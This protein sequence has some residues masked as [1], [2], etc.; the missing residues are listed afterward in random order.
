MGKCKYCFCLLN[1]YSRTML[2]DYFIVEHP[3]H[4]NKVDSI[5]IH[6]LQ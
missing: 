5:Y 6:A 2:V 1:I 4:P 3:Q